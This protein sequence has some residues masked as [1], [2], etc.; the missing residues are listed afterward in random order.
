MNAWPV[1][2][3]CVFATLALAA[4]ANLSAPPSARR[5][6][7]ALASLALVLGLSEFYVAALLAGVAVRWPWVHAIGLP[8][9][10]MLPPLAWATMARARRRRRLARHGSSSLA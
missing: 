2:M 4:A 5:A 3:H 1:L 9:V 8:I 6:R 7:P 10:A